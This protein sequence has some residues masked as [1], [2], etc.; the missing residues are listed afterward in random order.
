[1]TASQI[2]PFY[3]YRVE[4]DGA[5]GEHHINIDVEPDGNG[6]DKSL[7]YLALYLDSDIDKPGWNDRVIGLLL[8]PVPGSADDFSRVGYLAIRDPSWITRCM[9][10]KRN[11][12]L[13]RSILQ[14]ETWIYH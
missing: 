2:F 3:H 4:I 12:L 6:W 14:F 5:L 8:Q 9:T 7:I 10:P 11:R 13:E 1:M